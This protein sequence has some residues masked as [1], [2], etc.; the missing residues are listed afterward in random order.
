MRVGE[1]GGRLNGASTWP[2]AALPFPRA[3]ALIPKVLPSEMLG[4]QGNSETT[5]FLDASILFYLFYFFKD[6]F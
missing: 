3:T 1:G 2:D 5:L 6:F 4:P